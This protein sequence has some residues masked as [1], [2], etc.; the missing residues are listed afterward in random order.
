MLNDA[1]GC[2]FSSVGGQ[3]QTELLLQTAAQW[4]PFYEKT[5]RATIARHEILPNG[6]VR[7]T[8][9]NG[10]AVLINYAETAADDGAG[11]TVEP[12]G[13]VFIG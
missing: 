9:D 11:H 4:R 5:A 6:L 1:E 3:G 12:L 7:V 8:Y 10:C 2:S 13:F